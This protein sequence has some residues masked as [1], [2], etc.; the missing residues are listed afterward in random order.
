MIKFLL[1][2]GLVG[3][4]STPEA[5]TTVPSEIF[6][7]PTVAV[8]RDGFQDTG[9]SD[10]WLL[11]TSGGEHRAVL[12]IDANSLSESSGRKLVW[13]E[14]V[15][16][17]KSEYGVKRSRSRIEVDCST[18]RIG[19]REL[20]SF[21]ENGAE[22]P[23]YTAIIPK[24]EMTPVPSGTVYENVLS[25]VCDGKRRYDHLPAEKTPLSDSAEIFQLLDQRKQ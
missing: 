12:Y 6:D 21:D 17:T 1:T 14:R 2:A 13:L 20:R 15:Y 4:V 10:W 5:P 18:R 3:V 25:F 11:T 8:L 9:N 24:A 19:A 7:V 22:V 23:R 16:E